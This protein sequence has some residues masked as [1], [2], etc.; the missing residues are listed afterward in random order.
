MNY[1]KNKI[2]LFIINLS[3]SLGR[4]HY[5]RKRVFNFHRILN[6]NFKLEEDFYFVQIGANDGVSFDFLYDFVIARK[7]SGVVVEPIKEYFNELVNNYSNFEDIVKLNFAV[8]PTAK[9]A[10]IYKVNPQSFSKYPDWVKGIASFNFN[11]HLALNINSEDILIEQ[12]EC[13]PLMDL[14]LNNNRLDLLQI[15]TEGYDYEVLK[16]IDFMLI[17]PKL[18][19]YE[20][21]GLSDIDL[22]KSF[23]LLKTNGYFLFKEGGDIIGVNLETLDLSL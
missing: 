5:Y 11:H 19:K 6:S 3:T 13:K 17:K 4:G 8:H 20:F 23:E 10:K 15:D 14:V 16:M 2:L 1:F 12:V 21:V 9:S 7:S 18:I 22:K